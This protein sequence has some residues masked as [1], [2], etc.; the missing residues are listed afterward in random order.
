M[1]RHSISHLD[2]WYGIA[3]ACVFAAGFNVKYDSA[4]A[5]LNSDEVFPRSR[6]VQVVPESREVTRHGIADV[7]SSPRQKTRVSPQVIG[8]LP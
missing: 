4:D 2:S 7:L 8:A 5:Q 1:A 6:E 3:V